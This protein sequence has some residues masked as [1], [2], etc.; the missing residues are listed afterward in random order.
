M[1]FPSVD[2]Y[3]SKSL[4][5]TFNFSKNPGKPQTTMIKAEYTNLS[6]TPYVDFIFQAAVPKVTQKGV[7]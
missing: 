2:V 6:D 1:Q 3:L 7:M 4:K 5:V